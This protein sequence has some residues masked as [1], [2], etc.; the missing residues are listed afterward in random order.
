MGNST[1]L[2]TLMG[3]LHGVTVDGTMVD[4]GLTPMKEI[5]QFCYILFLWDVCKTRKGKADFIYLDE[6]EF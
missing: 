5:K 2:G 6:L 1:P 4:L 3:Y